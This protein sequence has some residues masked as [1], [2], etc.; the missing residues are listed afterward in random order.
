MVNV[1]FVEL[2]PPRRIVEA[3]SF[4]TTDPANRPPGIGRNVFRGPHYRSV[5]LSLV[6]RTGL[7]SFHAL[8]ESAALE[9]RANLFN[10]FNLLNLAPFGFFSPST[11]VNN[12]NFGRAT[13]GLAGRV[14][15]L[16]ARFSF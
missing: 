15:E 6:K 3:V 4:A 16:Q 10:A 12:G 9:L 7:P 8:G 5:D 13:A 14:I 2:A 11:D 1:R